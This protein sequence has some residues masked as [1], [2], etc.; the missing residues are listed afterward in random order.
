VAAPR[1]I[2]AVLTAFPRLATVSMDS[3][4]LEGNEARTLGSLTGTS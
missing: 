1:Q 3:M 4:L 2:E